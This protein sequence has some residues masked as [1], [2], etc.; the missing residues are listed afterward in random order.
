MLHALRCEEHATESGG[1]TYQVYKHSLEI[2][3]YHLF[4]SFSGKSKLYCDAEP[5]K[6]VMKFFRERRDNQI[7]SLELLSIAYGIAPCEHACC[8][9][10]SLL[11]M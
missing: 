1:D 7:M 11:F 8:H 6:E 10:G 2:V 3:F 5:S 4:I 9:A